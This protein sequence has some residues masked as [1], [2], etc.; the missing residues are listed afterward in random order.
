MQN[1]KFQP[2]SKTPPQ[3]LQSYSAA[4]EKWRWRLLLYADCAVAKLQF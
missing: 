4:K 3:T 2:Y 1:I